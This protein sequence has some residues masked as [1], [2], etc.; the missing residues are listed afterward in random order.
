MAGLR[1]WWNAKWNVTI[2]QQSLIDFPSPLIN[3]FKGLFK[4]FEM[5]VIICKVWHYKCFVNVKKMGL[6]LQL[7]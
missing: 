6:S 4:Y 3:L 2:L 1:P 7:L 5:Y